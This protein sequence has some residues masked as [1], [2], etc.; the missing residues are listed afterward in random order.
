M[1]VSGRDVY[2]PHNV[3]TSDDNF[4]GRVSVLRDVGDGTV[5]VAAEIIPNAQ[6]A[7]FGPLTIQSGLVDGAERDFVFWSRSTDSPTFIYGLFPTA[8]YTENDGM[9]VGSYNL[10]AFASWDRSSIAKPTVSSD[11][12]GLWVGGS[13]VAGWTGAAGPINNVNQIAP[14]FLSW[15]TEL[16]QPEFDPSQREYLL[17]VAV[18]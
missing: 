13:A 7:P 11:L 9:G 8:R 1:G 16:A 15:E 12:S 5:A 10:K 6:S 14:G 17:F 18:N 3:P 2:V 4:A